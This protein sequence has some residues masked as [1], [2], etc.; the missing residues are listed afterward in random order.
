MS[1]LIDCGPAVRD[2]LTRLTTPTRN[3]YYYGKLLDAFHLELEQDYGNRKR[4]LLNRL[5]LGTGVL[6]GLKVSTS[7]DRKQVRVGPGVAIDGWGREIVVDV[8]SPG[9]DPRQPTD[10]C[11]QNV[12]GPARG[13]ARMTLWICYHECEAEA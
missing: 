11:G 3:R 10:D 12:G 1:T 2:L 7:A 9:V 13:A 5:S 6:C 4:W 8:D